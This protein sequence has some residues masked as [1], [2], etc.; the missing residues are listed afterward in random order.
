MGNL[1]DNV[2]CMSPKWTLSLE[3]L[4]VKFV[5]GCILPSV[6]NTSI[7]L[8]LHLKGSKV[9]MIMELKRYEW[10]NPRSV[11]MDTVSD[12]NLM[13]VEWGRV[14]ELFW[15]YIKYSVKCYSTQT[16]KTCV[17][18]FE[19]MLSAQAVMSSV[20][21]PPQWCTQ[22]SQREVLAILPSLQHVKYTEMM[23]VCDDCPMWRQPTQ[24]QQKS[25]N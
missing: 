17:N 19:I 15:C 13:S 20:Q 5:C 8:R 9:G 24:N 10:E 6:S 21:V 18:A 1:V 3:I 25:C 7:Y 22:I 16:V 23:L 14:W 11:A 2:T 12:N 4:G